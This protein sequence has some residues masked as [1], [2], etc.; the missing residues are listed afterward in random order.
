[1]KIDLVYLWVDNEDKNWSCKKEQFTLEKT[2]SDEAINP[3]RFVNSDELK[4]S[5]R[6]VEM[7]APWINMI[8]IITDEQI[9]S[10]INVDNPKIKIIDHKDIIP[11]DKLPLFNSC[12]LE[13]RIP[14]IKDLSE[15]FLYA[16]DDT[17][18]WKAVDES[19][20]FKNNYP[21]IRGLKYLN[22]KKKYNGLYTKSILKAYNLIISKYTPYFYAFLPHHNIDAYKKST[23]INCIKEFP[24]DFAKNL[25]NRF[26]DDNDLQRVIVSYY[27]L[28][29]NQGYLKIVKK[30]LLEKIFNLETD[31]E[32]INIK[33]RTI[34]KINKVNTKL[35]CL[36]DNTQTKMDDKESIKQVLEC[37]F[38]KKSSFER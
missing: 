37:K 1:M 18:F 2:Y 28:V 36:N 7:N 10:W 23:F 11:A 38:N 33:S 17:Y 32:I 19:F 9:P 30:N 12:A 35:L 15:Y 14:Y 8:Y 26:R 34:K 4:Y 20:F 5:L 27:S 29:K 21:I 3:C 13:S 25:N 6:S 16:N 31:S 22:K 24:D